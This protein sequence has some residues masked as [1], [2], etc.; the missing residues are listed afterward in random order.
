[1]AKGQMRSN[2]EAK[3]PKKNAPEKAK[4]GS[5]TVAVAPSKKA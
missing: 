5:T 1:M 4:P 3:K 2:K